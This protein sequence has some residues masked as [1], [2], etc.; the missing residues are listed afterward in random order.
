MKKLII[1]ILLLGG[2]GIFIYTEITSNLSVRTEKRGEVIRIKLGSVNDYLVRIDTGYLLVDTSFA[3]DYHEFMKQLKELKISPREIKYLFLTHHHDDHAGFAARLLKET[4]AT[5]IVHEK[6]LA[7]LAQGRSLDTVVPANA[8]TKIVFEVFTALKD[9]K[10]E[11]FSYPPVVPEKNSIIVTGDERKILR[12]FG[13]AGD[14][15]YT[16]GHSSD[17]ITLLLDDGS[18]FAGDVAMNIMGFCALN[19]RP[20]YIEDMNQVFASWKKLLN[21]GAKVIYTAHGEPFPAEEL[22]R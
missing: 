14:I 9:K 12:R 3:G 19:H 18:A 4:G 15:L 5:L 16:P 8:C 20:I 11:N 1:T 6:A 2:A 10:H 17:S 22:K 7:P 13:I 21:E